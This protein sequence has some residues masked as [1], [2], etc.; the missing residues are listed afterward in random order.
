MKKTAY[1]IRGEAMGEM[2]RL[3][4]WAILKITDG[5][6]IRSGLSHRDI[7]LSRK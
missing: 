1:T 6:S 5:R 7:E 4:L 3:V 2:F